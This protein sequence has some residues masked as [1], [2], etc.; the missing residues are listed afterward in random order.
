[1]RLFL[2]LMLP[3]LALAA[4]PTDKPDAAASAATP[5]AQANVAPERAFATVDTGALAP[6][7]YALEGRGD[8]AQSKA[9]GS[10]RLRFGLT[11]HVEI[12]V[13]QS[14]EKETGTDVALGATPIAVRYALGT[15]A[16][17]VPLN[18]VLEVEYQPHNDGPDRAQVR[19]LLDSEPTK[20]V[21]LA[22]N[23]VAGRTFKLEDAL[24]DGE[25][26]ASF[27]AS[28]TLEVAGHAVH[29]GGEG[30]FEML[31]QDHERYQF[32]MEVGPSLQTKVGPVTANLAALVVVAGDDARVNPTA[33]L[34]YAF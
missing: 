1:M 13:G 6:G 22:A 16:E 21:K 7:H 10:V 11:D 12:S 27:G 18:P 2:L 20:G 8:L 32:H 14:V 34:S 15:L 17:P 31:Q 24:A 30:R 25:L 26:G 19:V 9:D 3:S 29:L 5:S 23:V 33:V 4:E 28:Y